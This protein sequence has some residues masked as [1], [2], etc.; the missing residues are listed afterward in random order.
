MAD[1]NVTV[2]TNCSN[3]QSHINFAKECLKTQIG[4]IQITF[5]ILKILRSILR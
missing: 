4:W 5:K 2:L 1:E 3:V